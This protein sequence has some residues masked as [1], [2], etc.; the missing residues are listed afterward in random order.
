MFPSRRLFR[1]WL[2]AGLLAAVALSAHF[3]ASQAWAQPEL[4][5]S[6]PED[7]A[8]LDEPPDAINLCFSEP[9]R[10]G[11]FE[12]FEFAVF[13]PENQR[14]GL[15]A[16]FD[17]DGICVEINPGRPEGEDAGLWEV[18][19]QVT[20]RETEETGT[21]SLSFTVIGE[22]TPTPTL[23]PT[24]EAETPT[25]TLLPTPP[26]PG[27]TPTP[28]RA[29]SEEDGGPDILTVALITAGAIIGASV[30]GLALYLLRRRIGFWPHRPPPDEGGDDSDRA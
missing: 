18:R 6:D 4:D 14:L 20:S 29:D 13:A 23:S 11:G 2:A 24:P 12:D 5:Q 30:L 28:E 15:R 22:E 16:E 8:E 27:T 3:L 21:G 1:L 25:P 26:A 9:V 17:A 7:G 19:W 10:S